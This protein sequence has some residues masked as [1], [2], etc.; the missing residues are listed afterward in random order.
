MYETVNIDQMYEL[1][2]TR[3]AAEETTSQNGFQFLRYIFSSGEKIIFEQIDDDDDDSIKVAF[4]SYF[5][6]FMQK[7]IVYIS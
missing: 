4:I 5:L 3:A 7:Y 1:Q 2:R 6:D